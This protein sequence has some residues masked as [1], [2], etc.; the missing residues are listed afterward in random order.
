VAGEIGPD[1]LLISVSN[2]NANKL[3]HLL[4]VR[5]GIERVPAPSNPEA[6]VDNPRHHH[7]LRLDL[8]N[9]ATGLES[10]EVIGELDPGRYFGIVAVHLPQG[11][12]NMTINGVPVPATDAAGELR[13]PIVQ[14]EGGRVVLNG[15]DQ[16]NELLGVTVSLAPE[17]SRTMRLGFTLPWHRPIRLLPSGRYPSVQW[18]AVPNADTHAVLLYSPDQPGPHQ[19]AVGD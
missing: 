5:A 9:G 3:D 12:A 14:R 4:E 8:R 11:A 10:T 6:A 18:L 13:G 1:D 7:E 15:P 16:Y 17:E 2:H 19:P